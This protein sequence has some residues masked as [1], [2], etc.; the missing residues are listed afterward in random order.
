MNYEEAWG[1]LKKWLIDAQDEGFPY[2]VTQVLEKIQEAEE[3]GNEA[4]H[5]HGSP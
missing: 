4:A 1:E 2:T 5:R 3:D